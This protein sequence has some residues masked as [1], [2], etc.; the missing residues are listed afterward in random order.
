MIFYFYLYAYHCICVF[1]NS[2]LYIILSYPQFYH[3][4]VR[5]KSSILIENISTSFSDYVLIVFVSL[6]LYLWKL[7]HKTS[8]FKI[9]PMNFPYFIRNMLYK[10]F[11]FVRKCLHFIFNYE[12]FLFVFLSMYLSFFQKIFNNLI[13]E[14]EDFL[15]K[16]QIQC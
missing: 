11:S 15:E 7:P 16:T 1:L 14:I 4:H 6:P 2:I 12:I 9:F 13:Y 10:I 5:E 3:T 8:F